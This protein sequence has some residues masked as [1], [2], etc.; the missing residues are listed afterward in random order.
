MKKIFIVLL[1]SIIGAL[2]VEAQIFDVAEIQHNGDPDKYINLV[3]MGDGYTA[4][5][6]DSF[7]ATAQSITS[8]L[9][10]ISPFAE[11]KKYFNVYA[12]KVIAGESGVKHANTASDCG[13]Y[14]TTVSNPINYFGTRFDGFGIHRLTI[15]TNNSR[16]VNTLNANFP[17]YDQVFIVGNST[18]YGGSGGQ[19]A[20]FSATTAS[21]EIAA[22]ELGHSFAGLA[23]EYY[24]GDQYFAEKPNMTQ[25]SDQNIIKWKNW[26]TDDGT[27]EIIPYGGSGAAATWFK[28]TSGTCKMEQLNRPYCNVCKEGIVEKIHSLVNTI[29]SFTPENNTNIDVSETLVN[30]QLTEL[31]Q[32]IPN[33][34]HIKWQLDAV[35]LDTNN[36]N[37]QIDPASLTDGLHTLTASVVDENPLVRTDNHAALHISTVTWTINKT[38]LGVHTDASTSKASIRVYPNPVSNLL[39]FNFD[40]ENPATIAIDIV[41]L[42]GKTVQQLAQKKSDSGQFEEQLSVENLASGTYIAVMKIDGV[43]YSKAF[44]K[45]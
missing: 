23:D 19:Y 10:S 38:N 3:I 2:P 40:L 26:I 28:P 31:M 9:F 18:Q 6:Q 45:E 12:I 14:F 11:Y 7:M 5:E 41:N 37:F 22:H 4:A 29:V 30:F 17:N 35:V 15:V 13:G 32:P 16:V 43:P 44:V 24:A 34:L 27:I 33:T 42:D 20:V 25:E 36:E 8:Y 1:I 21:R 39:T